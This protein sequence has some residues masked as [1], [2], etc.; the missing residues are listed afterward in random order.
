[1]ESCLVVQG[2]TICENVLNIKK[3]WDGFPV[4][5]STW[6]GS[7]KNCY[8][9]DDVVIYNEYPT[10]N[11][12][13]NLNL[14]KVSSLNGF[15]KAKELGYDRVIKWRQD[16][17]PSDYTKLIKLFKKD[18]INLYAYMIHKHGYITD[19]FMEGEINDMIN[20]FN[21]TDIN[22]PYPEFAFTKRLFEI[23]LDKKSNFIC[24][25]LNKEN[26]IFWKSK[27]IW[28]SKNISLN[29]FTNNIKK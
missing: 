9:V 13:K 1:M 20:L 16:F 6:E 12:I 22:V 23:K 26:D 2:P 27:N 19:Y 7:N 24:K 21:I 3:Y 5:F 29:T 4:I 15:I 14:Q 17:Y 11:G 18:S 10:N 25:D 8:S 28:L